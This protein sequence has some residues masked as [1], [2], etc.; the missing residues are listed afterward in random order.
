MTMESLF[1]TLASGALDKLEELLKAG[2]DVNVQDEQGE[3]LLFKAIAD[4][5][6]T[7]VELLFDYKVDCEI[8]NAKGYLPTDCAEKAEFDE[9]GWI[10]IGFKPGYAKLKKILIKHLT[11]LLYMHKGMLFNAAIDDSAYSVS[12]ATANG[13]WDVNLR[14]NDGRTPLHFGAEKGACRAVLALLREEE[15]IIRNKLRAGKEV[16]IAFIDSQDS[17]G[18]TALHYAAANANQAM[19]RILLQA[20]ARAQIEDIAGVV[21]ENLTDDV[22]IKALFKEQ[23]EKNARKEKQPSQK[24]SPLEKIESEIR[25]NLVFALESEYQYGTAVGEKLENLILYCGAGEE[26]GCFGLRVN[27]TSIATM[28]EAALEKSD[29]LDFYEG[30]VFFQA[31]ICTEYMIEGINNLVGDLFDFDPDEDPSNT[32]AMYYLLQRVCTQLENDKTPLKNISIGDKWK[33]YIND[34]DYINY[35]G[36]LKSKKYSA[37]STQ[38]YM[39]KMAQDRLTV[40]PVLGV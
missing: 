2:A 7:A 16:D 25:D 26:A 5:N 8:K 28:D 13:A 14:L 24:Q 21:A 4:K 27:S 40:P 19:T 32:D 20:G 9:Y 22:V 6:M 38:A 34:C 39:E 18:K 15:A 30:T 10:K 37:L 33:I 36:R 31:A 1:Q 3:T 29:T 17:K 35:K 11:S 23:P 12:A